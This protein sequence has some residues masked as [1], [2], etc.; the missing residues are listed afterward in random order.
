MEGSRFQKTRRMIPS[1]SSEGDGLLQVSTAQTTTQISDSVFESCGV[2]VGTGP[3]TRSALQITLNSS[4]SASRSLVISSCLFLDSHP[5]SSLSASLHIRLLTGHTTIV[6][7]DSWFE[8]TTSTHAWMRFES[9][10]ACLDWTRRML[11]S[12]SPTLNG[13]LVEYS[14]G[15]PIVV[16]RR[17]VFSNCRLVVVKQ[18]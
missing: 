13:A 12:S 11:E 5:S 15:L 17:G 1:S 4:S 8:K 6:L 16:R 2:V 9:G 3:I 7:K 10:I 14:D 18:A